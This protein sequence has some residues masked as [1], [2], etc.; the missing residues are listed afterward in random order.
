MTRWFQQSKRKDEKEKASALSCSFKGC[1]DGRVGT[2]C[3][4][5]DQYF[6]VRH[7]YPDDHGCTRSTTHADEKKSGEGGKPSVTGTATTGDSGKSFSHMVPEGVASV[8]SAGNPVLDWYNVCEAPILATKKGED[9]LVLGVHFPPQSPLQPRWMGF[10]PRWSMGRVL[11]A[12][13][14]K[15]GL[16]HKTNEAEDKRWHLFSV[17]TGDLVTPPS[18]ILADVLAEG[19]FGLKEKGTGL[20]LLRGSKLQDPICL[21]KARRETPPLLHRAKGCL[22]Q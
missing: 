3:V 9:Y 19:R 16:I 4:A 20:L 6:C 11:D 1:R 14:S 15:N 2:A 21:E 22:V 8:L 18:A 12:I 10:S 5:C 13:T 7:R 17:E